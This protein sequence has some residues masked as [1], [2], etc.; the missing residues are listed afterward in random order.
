MRRKAEGI[1]KNS[2][3]HLNGQ[4]AELKTIIIQFLLFFD[5]KLRT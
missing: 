4:P 2:A 3:G 1:N 5:F